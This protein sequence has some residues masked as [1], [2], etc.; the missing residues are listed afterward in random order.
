MFFLNSDTF[1]LFHSGVTATTTT[2]TTTTLSAFKRSLP[3]R[4]CIILFSSWHLMFLWSC[5]CSRFYCGYYYIVFTVFSLVLLLLVLRCPTST[6]LYQLH[7][8]L[9]RFP[10]VYRRYTKLS[11]WIENW[12]MWPRNGQNPLSVKFKIAVTLNTTIT[13][14]QT[15]RFCEHLVS[16]CPRKE[17]QNVL[18]TSSIKLGRFQ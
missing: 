17:S 15:V 1:F 12:F 5:A 16:P 11:G 2:T 3:S 4:I 14:P 13:Q 9:F 7:V 6:K 18:V 8:G 10:G